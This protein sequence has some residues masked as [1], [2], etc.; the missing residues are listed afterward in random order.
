MELGH[1]LSDDQ[2]DRAHLEGLR[3]QDRSLLPDPPECRKPWCIGRWMMVHSRMASYGASKD[4]N[5]FS[6]SLGLSHSLFPLCTAPSGLLFSAKLASPHGSPNTA[7]A[8]YEDF[9]MAAFPFVY[10]SRRKWVFHGKIMVNCLVCR[11]LGLA[12]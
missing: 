11:S 5:G 12:F 7:D 10:D 2:P 1:R 8:I 9:C 3:F 4:G 6:R